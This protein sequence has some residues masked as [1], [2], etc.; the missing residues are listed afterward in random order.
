MN[1]DTPF[2]QLVRGE[3]PLCPMETLLHWQFEHFDAERKLLRVSYLLD[4]RFTNPIGTI[5]GGA[6]AA[7][8]D[9]IIGPLV[10]AH[11]SADQFAPTLELKSSFLRSARPGRFV[12]EGQLLKLGRQ[13]AFSEARLLNHAGELIATASATSAIQQRH[14]PSSS[15]HFGQE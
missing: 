1:H 13:F 11:L 7:M 12:G 3:R 4:E 9:N 5:H 15:P 14:I 8:L 2:W 6:I 10:V